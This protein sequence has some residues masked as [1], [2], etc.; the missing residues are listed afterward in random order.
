M[1]NTFKSAKQANVTAAHV[2]YSI[3]GGVG[4]VIGF[5]LSNTGVVDATV[6]VTV[7]SVK[8][9]HNVLLPIGSTLSPVFGKLVVE[10][11]EN[12]TVA[13]DVSM[14]AHVSLMEI[15]P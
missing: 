11:G 1:A 4:V 10:D 7:G 9:L 15:T 14:D 8:L 2:L 13:S 5:H 12:I 3:T 6:N